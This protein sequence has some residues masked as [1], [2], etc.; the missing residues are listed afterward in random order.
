MHDVSADTHTLTLA[1]RNI[2]RIVQSSMYRH[3]G[4]KPAPQDERENKKGKRK[5]KTMKC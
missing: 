3:A 1:Q 4:S 2:Y 5:I